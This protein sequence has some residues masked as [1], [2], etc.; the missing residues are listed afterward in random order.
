MND[1]KKYLYKRATSIY[2]S[3]YIV[4]QNIYILLR[5]ASI[6]ISSD[7]GTLG[8]RKKIN[9]SQKRRIQSSYRLR[10]VSPISEIWTCIRGTVF[11]IP[12]VEICGC[13]NAVRSENAARDA[14]KRPMQ[15]A[16]EKILI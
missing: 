15:R 2:I 10:N 4:L 5:E 16:K 14:A 13:V 9:A 12:P 11:S 6:K 8:R 3:S 1:T 7:C